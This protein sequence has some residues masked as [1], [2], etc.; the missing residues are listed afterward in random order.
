MAVEL[1]P[2]EP[3]SIE[4]RPPRR[5]DLRA[6]WRLSAWGGAAAVA[7]VA[8]AI[9][10]QTE[11]GSR[12]LAAIETASLDLPVRSV[13]TVQIPKQDAQVAKLEAQM[14]TLAADRDRLAERVAGLEQNIEDLTGSVKRQA[15]QI[16]QPAGPPILSM[17]PGSSTSP[18]AAAPAAS[19][20]M[21]VA[22]KTPDNP[23]ENVDASQPNVAPSSAP[24]QT[25]KPGH[26]AVPMP[27]V[28]VASLPPEPAKL[29]F[30]VALA[31]ASSLDVLHLQWAALKANYGPLLG[32][33]RPIASRE[34]RGTATYYRLV[35][36]P[37][38]NL[39]T[40]SKLCAHLT[41]ARA[42]CH[43]GKFAGDPL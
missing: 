41:A 22:A 7:L 1:V 11:T 40:A 33:L 35:L 2:P 12:R 3:E 37:L 25:A 20:P 36:G 30:G 5:F 29:E 31:S 16:S 8:V 42:P 26:D 43:A 21:T 15:A 19:S 17:V 38:P 39:A 34:Q 10:T 14:R 4:L 18:R 24:E 9:A 32:G 6:L 23:S 27:P 28:R 13:A